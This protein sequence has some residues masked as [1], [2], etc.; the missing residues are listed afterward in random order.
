MATAWIDS[1]T[2]RPQSRLTCS[3]V[4]QTSSPHQ[5][6]L[7]S[8]KL[9][10]EEKPYVVVDLTGLDLVED[11]HVCYTGQERVPETLSN[12]WLLATGCD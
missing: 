9:G 4:G 6:L 1:P 5:R 2:T 10:S 3:S 7:N 11:K 8:E 12:A